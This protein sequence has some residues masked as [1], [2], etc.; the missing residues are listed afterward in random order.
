MNRL[1][2]D[3]VRSQQKRVAAECAKRQLARSTS[4]TY[5]FWTGQYLL[6][7][8]RNSGAGAQEFLDDLASRSS[9]ATVR[10][11]LNALAFFCNRVLGRE[12]PKLRIA[13]P[14]KDRRAPVVLTHDEIARILSRL[15]PRRRIMVGLLYG[16]GLRVGELV[17]LRIKDIDIGRQT[18]TVRAGKGDKDRSTVLPASIDAAGLIREARRVWEIDRG[19]GIPPGEPSASLGKKL[20]SSLATN[21]AWGWVFPSQRVTGG[22]RWHATPQPLARALAAAARGAKIDK[23]VSPHV[24]RHT[25][26]TEM[27]RGGTD[28]RTVQSLLGHAKLE[29]TMIYMHALSAEGAAVTSPLDR[30]RGVIVPFEAANREIAHRIVHL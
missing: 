21:P 18:I 17:T 4:K 10:Q 5:Q 13:R 11:A 25:F 2:P 16:S 6:F 9:K 29:T 30:E 7:V 24:L 23:R 14:A 12:L 27:L 15:G 3:W 20:G 22:K 26:A 1:M 28:I 8:S 19:N